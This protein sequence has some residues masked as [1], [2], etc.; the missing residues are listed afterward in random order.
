MKA[1]FV[2]VN[3]VTRSEEPLVKETQRPS[4][5]YRRRRKGC[6]RPWRKPESPRNEVGGAVR[7]PAAKDV[8][9]VVHID[10]GH[11]GGGVEHR[12]AAVGRDRAVADFGRSVPG[13][14]G[15][16]VTFCGYVPD[17]VGDEVGV[18]GNEL[19]GRGEADQFPSPLIVTLPVRPLLPAPAG[20]VRRLTSTTLPVFRS[21]RNTFVSSG[22]TP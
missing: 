7:K 14:S 5:R 13:D 1:P 18:R 3:G 11:N 12:I 8:R 22:R 15:S 19:V 2:S 17:E 9:L 21:L 20:P 4:P 6:H 10:S 16:V